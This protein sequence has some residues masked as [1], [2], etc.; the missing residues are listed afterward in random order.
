MNHFS[1]PLTHLRIRRAAPVHAAAFICPAAPHRGRLS[2]SVYVRNNFVNPARRT[3][4]A[5]K[6]KGFEKRISIDRSEREPGI[7][8]ASRDTRLS[9]DRVISL[10]TRNRDLRNEKNETFS[11]SFLLRHAVNNSFDGDI[12][13]NYFVPILTRYRVI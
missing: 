9:R 8:R 6:K 4:C 12:E 1:E 5:Q 2:L 10:F 11:I 3:E 13:D 7:R